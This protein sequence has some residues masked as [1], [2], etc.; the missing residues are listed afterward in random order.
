M[1]RFKGLDQRRPSS[2]HKRACSTVGTVLTINL[3]PS[4]R[5]LYLLLL[6][7]I[8]AINSL[9]T[10]RAECWARRANT[11][12]FSAAWVSSFQKYLRRSQTCWDEAR[13][14]KRRTAMRTCSPFCFETSR[15]SPNTADR[16]CREAS[17][18]LA[19]SCTTSSSADKEKCG[20]TGFLPRLGL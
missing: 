11:P 2:H 16:V 10:R 17:W 18:A 1:D 20:R 15:M 19:N 12:A 7:L 13:L 4:T 6:P 14:N 5:G 9:G 8:E 3:S